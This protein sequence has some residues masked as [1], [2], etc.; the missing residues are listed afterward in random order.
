VR[1]RAPT[2]AA[3]G[4]F[5]ADMP[6]LAQATRVYDEYLQQVSTTGTGQLRYYAVS[7]IGPR[8][9]IDKM[10]SKLALLT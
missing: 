3:A 2:A 9:T 4:V 5:M 1:R 8:N 6:S 7:V 10:V